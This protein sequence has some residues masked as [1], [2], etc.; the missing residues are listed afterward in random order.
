MRTRLS[1]LVRRGEECGLVWVWLRGERKSANAAGYARAESGKVQ[2]RAGM[3]V[4]RG[5]F[6]GL[7]HGCKMF[8]FRGWGAEVFFCGAI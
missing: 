4:L 2:T 3:V 8:G 6:R 7:S 1:M 5:G